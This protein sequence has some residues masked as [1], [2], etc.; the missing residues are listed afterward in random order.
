MDLVPSL[1]CALA[2]SA[3]AGI[4]L[5][6]ASAAAQTAVATRAAVGVAPAALPG[7]VPAVRPPRCSVQTEQARLAL[8]LSRTGF[9]LAAGYPIKIVAIGS[10]ST[11]GAGASAPAYAYPSRLEEELE[12][13]F[14]GHE[15]TVLNRG[16]NGE[17]AENMLARFETSVIS[18]QPHLVLWQVGTN[19]LLRDHPLDARSP[20]L[21]EGL[22]RLRAIRA[23]IVLIDPQFAPKVNSKPGVEDLVAS[24]AT[25]A[26]TEK[27]DVFSRYAVMRRW[28]DVDK[29]AFDAF[30]SPDGLHMNDWSY[31]CFA[32]WLGAAIADAATR[33]TATASAPRRTR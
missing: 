23:D 6:A 10:S 28:Y 16:V 11:A 3:A 25:V 30:V 20:V 33:P 12:Q 13:H 26:K 18:E 22:A 29:L 4:V 9:R 15:F 19:S 32:R 24:I 17:E 7:A 5:A 27:V 8:P 1:R 31:G 2:F 14:P 21:H